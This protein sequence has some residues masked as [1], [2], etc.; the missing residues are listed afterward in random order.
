M[1]L[2]HARMPVAWT[3]IHLAELT[4]AASPI[5]TP[6]PCIL[7]Q[8]YTL[9]HLLTLS[10]PIMVASAERSHLRASSGGKHVRFTSMQLRSF[11]STSKWPCQAIRQWHD[12]GHG[13][14][15]TRTHKDTQR[16][17]QS[18]NRCLPFAMSTPASHL[19][20]G[21]HIEHGLVDP[22]ASRM[23]SSLK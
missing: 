9:P 15:D 14:I 18:Q 1:H 17:T 21:P 12:A 6:A 2:A 13:H 23:S 19:I 16:D 8:Q 11:C 22:V 10:T 3:I 5:S 7:P 4:A 20:Q